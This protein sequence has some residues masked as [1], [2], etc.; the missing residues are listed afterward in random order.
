MA[1]SFDLI[2]IGGGPGGYICAIRAAQLGMNVACVEKS[3]TLGGTCLNV[4]CIPSKALLHSSEIYAHIPALAEM[5][6]AA[7][8]V[9]LD[10][11]AMMGHKDKTVDELTK[12]IAF[13][14]KKNKVTP[15]SGTAKITAPGTVQ[16]ALNEGG[17]TTLTAANIVVATGSEPAGLP[18]IEIDEERI[19][20]STGAL[21]LPEVPKQLL[22]VGGGVIGLELGSVWA[23]LGSEVT[24]LEFLDHIVPGADSD[25]RKEFQRAL[26]KQGIGFRLSTKVTGI[27]KT[28]SGLKVTVEPADG[29]TAEELSADVALIAIGRRPYTAGLGLEDIGVQMERGMIVTDSHYQTN[30]SGIFAIGDVIAG[31]M[32]AHKA[33]DEGVAVAELLAGQ[34]G[35]VNYDAI[36]S[37]VYTAP[38]VA[39]VGKTEDELKADNIEYRAGKAPFAANARAK[40]A[41]ETAGFVKILADAKT[42]RILGVH[43]IGPD[44]GNMIS[45]AT[46]AMEFGGAAEDLAR[47]C[48]AHPTLAETIKEAA[49][50]VDKRTLN[51]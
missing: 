32:L 49:L 34:S 3:D 1:D 40:A 5:G 4:G 16:V 33:E 35:H 10:L 36:P 31:P 17:N 42:D 8:S 14:F 21:S 24:V 45:E 38:E 27:E 37:V 19:V 20:S 23:R 41:G 44:A 12:G 6:I 29:G 13:L 50:A 48:H 39:W 30:I 25:V 46:L 28:G 51:C 15:I 18:G 9:S 7:G 47:T 22:V 26:K 43:I 2:V 11:A